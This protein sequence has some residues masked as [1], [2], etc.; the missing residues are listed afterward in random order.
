MQNQQQNPQFVI[1]GSQIQ[2]Q[3]GTEQRISGPGVYNYGGS[4]NSGI[5]DN[6][7]YP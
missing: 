3:P 6:N 7:S 5:Y 4:Y 2:S 1:R